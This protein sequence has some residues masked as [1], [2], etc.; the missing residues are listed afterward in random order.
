MLVLLNKKQLYNEFQKSVQRMELSPDKYYLVVVPTDVD[1]AGLREAFAEL[2][3]L[4]NVVVLQADGV[5]LIE[6]N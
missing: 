4:V 6:L 2:A 3:G 5:K 1:E